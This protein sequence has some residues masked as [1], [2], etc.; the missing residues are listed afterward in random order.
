MNIRD[1]RESNQGKLVK[2]NAV[3]TEK[4]STETS[5]GSKMVN[6]KLTD[7]TGIISTPIFDIKTISEI[8]S[9]EIMKVYEVRGTINKWNDATQLRDV[10]LN[11]LNEGEYDSGDFIE[12]YDVSKKEID[13]FFS[14]V[15]SMKK[16]Y[17]DIA[18]K[19]TGMDN[20][21]GAKLSKFMKA[22]SAEKH[23]G[24]KVG[25]LFLHTVGVMKNIL[26]TVRIYEKYQGIDVDNYVNIDR[27]L[28]KAILHDV[29]K[30][31]EYEYDVAIKRKKDVV[32]HIYDGITILVNANNETGNQLDEAEIENIKRGLLSHHGQ[33]GPMEPNNTEDMILH[34]ADMIDSR[35]VG[36]I[37][38]QLNSK[39]E[40]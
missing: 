3:L 18:I 25:G 9:L 5:T 24:A 31:D 21:N 38:L 20:A 19:A 29:G 37:D 10:K 13:F 11:L 1:L 28:L 15:E 16:G 12:S 39:E 7:K 14:I 4:N 34:L 27:L 36:E 23:H 40:A 17:K 2:F 26:S 6:I 32:G 22:P 35:M 8:E 30:I 33:Y